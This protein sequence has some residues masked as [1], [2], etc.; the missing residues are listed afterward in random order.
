MKT[1]ILKSLIKEAVREVFQE[2]MKSII[3]EAIKSPNTKNVVKENITTPSTPSVN[4]KQAY[5]N[6][7]SEMGL[8]GD[9]MSFNSSDVSKF[10]SSPTYNPPPT[11]TLGEGSKLPDG[12]V[13]LDQIMG[14]LNK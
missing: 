3:M 9:T 7:L 11:S 13:N 6:I 5:K 10:S 14:L 8:G 12:E 2:E 1:N 4:P